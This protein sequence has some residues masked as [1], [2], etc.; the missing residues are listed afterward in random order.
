MA[1]PMPPLSALRAFEAAA[2]HLSMS[3]A[4]RELNVTAGALSHQ[5]RGLEEMLGVRL[6]ERRV[7]AIA[8]TAAGKQLYPGLQ[9]GFAQI[10]DA[11]AGLAVA[12]Q[13]NVLVVS[14]SPGM[15]SK[16]LAPRLYKFGAAHPDIDV[17]ISSSLTNANFETD[18]IDLAVRNMSVTAPPDRMLEVE[19]LADITFIPVC[20]PRLI[21]KHGPVKTAHD[22]ARLPLIHDE[23]LK[24]RAA[25]ADWKDWFTA[26]GVTDADLRRG[27]RFNSADH[28]LDA[29]GESAGVLL[30]HSLLAY[31]DLRTGRLVIPVKLSIA[32][33][34]AFHLVSARGRK[35]SPA[36]EAFKSWIKDEVAALD[37]RKFKTRVMA[38][39]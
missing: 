15:T 10:R 4:A 11:V 29:A 38:Q 19:R 36:A 30:A 17:R 33:G 39:L 37:W 20:S 3:A 14:T 35:P 16:W 12:G 18:G 9:T 8:L 34:R 23:T 1:R 31:D 27:L 22:L 24:S 21:D 7:R 26:A 5:I 2:R 6:F 25:Q 13:P 28:A 32:P